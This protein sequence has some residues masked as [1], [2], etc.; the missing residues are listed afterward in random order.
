MAR[1]SYCSTLSAFVSTKAIEITT[2][3]IK[4]RH[5]NDLLQKTQAAMYNDIELL[6]YFNY[7]V[8]I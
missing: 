7:G 3:K 6:I 4:R 8:M 5:S 1:K 2:T